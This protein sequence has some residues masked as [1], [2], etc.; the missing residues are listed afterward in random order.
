M[1]PAL[2]GSSVRFLGER[3]QLASLGQGSTPGWAFSYGQESL[4]PQCREG[5]RA[6]TVWGVCNWGAGQ[7]PGVL[8]ETEDPF[9]IRE[10]CL[11]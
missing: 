4:D 2:L 7:L 1:N 11:D 8:G 10:G 3:I 5:C 6:L 9:R